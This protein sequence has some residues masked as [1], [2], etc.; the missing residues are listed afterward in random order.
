[1]SLCVHAY[2]IDVFV[3]NLNHGCVDA[4]AEALDL[5][6]REE[7]VL[8]GAIHLDVRV[9]LNCLNDIAGSSQHARSGAAY[10]KMI[11]ADLGA[12]EHGV[13]GGDLVDLHGLHVE[14]LRDLV[15]RRESQKVIVLLL[16]NKQ[17]RDA[18]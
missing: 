4:G 17:S 8:T 11:L 18:R 10:L 7:A 2:L 12:V 9:I 3:V 5:A 14:D 15:H 6:E 16:C 1:V 13:E